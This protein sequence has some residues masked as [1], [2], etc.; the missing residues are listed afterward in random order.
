MAA[1]HANVSDLGGRRFY[2]VS[3]LCTFHC[4]AET[5]TSRSW[6]VSKFLKNIVFVLQK[7]QRTPSEPRRSAWW[8]RHSSQIGTIKELRVET[9]HLSQKE[10]K[11]KESKQQQQKKIQGPFFS[12]P[13]PSPPVSFL[14]IYLSALLKVTLPA[15]PET[16][17]WTPS[18]PR[19]P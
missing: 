4:S 16:R 14:F 12:A 5:W 19:N 2:Q 13:P 1:P 3:S 8:N 7:P 11:K 9:D 18:A 6:T 10:R 15:T 17:R